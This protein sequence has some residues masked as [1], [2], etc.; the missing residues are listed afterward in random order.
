MV[1]PL[2]N[3]AEI[4]GRCAN[5]DADAFGQLVNHYQEL[6]YN[7]VVRMLGNREDAQD[8]AQKVFLKAYRRIETFQGE[9]RFG[10]WLCS[11]AVNEAVSER[12]RQSAIRRSGAMPL[13]ALD[14]D[15]DSP[16]DPPADGPRPEQPLEAEEMMDRIRSAIDELSDDYRAVVVLRDIEGLDYKAISQALGCSHGTIKSRLHRARLQLRAKLKGLVIT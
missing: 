1:D 10:T 13:S 7:V 5:G 15:P 8:V 4:I 9:S 6:I 3:E 11:I 16:F 14:N 12:R 2:H